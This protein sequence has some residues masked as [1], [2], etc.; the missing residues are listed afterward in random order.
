MMNKKEIILQHL[1]Q[2]Y[3]ESYRGPL[4]LPG[5]TQMVLGDG[6]PHAQLMLIGE[7]PG[8]EEDLQGKPFV[9]RSGKLIEQVLRHAGHQRDDLFITNAVKSRPEQNR[10]PTP[11]EIA[12]ARKLLLAEIITISPRVICTLGA[13]ALRAILNEEV[14]SLAAFRGKPLT[15]QQYTIVPTYHPAYILR[16]PAAYK[17]F[18]HDLKIALAL[19]YTP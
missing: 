9:G 6:N 1:Y 16:Q 2:P 14:H 12:K 7:A 8:R 11:E 13:V 18:E 5:S 19:A 3:K 10:T 15:W 17:L 4:R